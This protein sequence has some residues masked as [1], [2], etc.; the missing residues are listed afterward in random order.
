VHPALEP[1]GEARKGEQLALC[2]LLSRAGEDRLGAV[3]VFL[4][5]DDLAQGLEEGAARLALLGERKERAR[6]VGLALV[7]E[8]ARCVSGIANPQ[9]VHHAEVEC[10]ADDTEI[11]LRLRVVS[12]E[13]VAERRRRI[14][15]DL[16]G[17]R[18]LARISL[19]QLLDPSLI[20]QEPVPVTGHEA[21]ERSPD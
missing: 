11:S 12:A 10:L 6:L 2:R 1:V 9:T 4:L 20:C 3:P 15:S 14:G 17:R 8:G 5:G 19:H 7:G 13:L 21:R 18:Q 16:N